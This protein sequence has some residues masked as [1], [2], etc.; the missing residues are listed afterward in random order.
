MRIT[1]LMRNH[2]ARNIAADHASRHMRKAQRNRWNDEDRAVC[3]DK[4]KALITEDERA[5]FER[6]FAEVSKRLGVK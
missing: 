6:L 1:N 4:Y 2:V 3:I 5:E